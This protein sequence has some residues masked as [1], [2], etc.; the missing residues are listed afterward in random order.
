MPGLFKGKVVAVK[1]PNSFVEQTF[2]KEP[3]RA[4][5]RRGM[6]ELTGAPDWQSAWRTFF[7]KTDVV[8]VKFNPVGRPAVVGSREVFA[9]IFA[10]L[11]ACGIPRKNMVAYDRYRNEFFAAGFDKWL[12]DG[13]R[14]MWAA[15]DYEAV[16]LEIKGY[17]PNHYLDMALTLPG[18]PMSVA[19]N[20]RSHAANFITREVSKL[21]NVPLLK[22][23]ASAGVTLALKNI[24][25][26]LVNNVNRTHSTRTLNACG[27]FIPAAVSLPAIRN[28]TVLHILDGIKAMYQDGPQGMKQ[29]GENKHVFEHH[30]VYF[31]TDPVALD[32]TCAPEVDKARAL[33]GLKP[34]AEVVDPGFVRRQP[35]HI[36]IAGALGLGES[37]PKKINVVR[38]NL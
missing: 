19:R 4:M 29:Y 38:V 36:E 34:V 23:H 5:L 15:D 9:E 25:H 16:Q 2:Q 37:E 24:S 13:V 17:D 35:E 18:Y 30:T 26:G 10:G 7:D 21:V 11:E 12:P 27:A 33:R 31:A 20:R 8:G 3:I 6:I 1:D 22:D 28:K 14:I 32:T